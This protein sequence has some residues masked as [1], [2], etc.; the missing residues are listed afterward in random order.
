MKK[1]DFVRN[2]QSGKI[3]VANYDNSYLN[4][5]NI[6]NKKAYEHLEKEVN[7]IGKNFGT[8]STYDDFQ[9]YDSTGHLKD[10]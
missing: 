6:M 8:V 4:A 3:Y 1:F 5:K 10:F 7:K 2:E 9:K